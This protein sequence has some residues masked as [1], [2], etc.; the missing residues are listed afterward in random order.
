MRA[1]SVNIRNSTVAKRACPG[2]SYF[3]SEM[4]LTTAVPSQNLNRNVLMMQLAEDWD[5]CDAA[6]LV[7]P[8][9]LW[10]VLLQ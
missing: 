2:F 5:R 9:E 4:N 1:G 3:D 7:P 10:S 6:E 8:P